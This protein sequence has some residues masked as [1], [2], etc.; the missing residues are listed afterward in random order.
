MFSRGHL[1]QFLRSL[2]L[3]NSRSCRMVC[4]TYFI[5]SFS[6]ERLECLRATY[7]GKTVLFTDRS[8]FTN[9]QIVAAY[10]SAWHVE[11][12]FK[13]MKNTTIIT[14]RPIFHWTDEKICVH[15]FVCV[16]AY[17]LCCLLQKELSENAGITI[18]INKLID[19]M[20]RI[21]RIH[22]FIGDINK[23]NKI[24]SFTKGDDIATKIENIYKL[25]EKYS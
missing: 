22:T 23:P 4:N 5:Y 15:V 25:I 11:S 6:E 10:R 7:L 19:G 9:E 2:I 24:E 20:S 3:G 14:V 18:S 21:K 12:A 17:R 1:G 16:L 13:T 8:D